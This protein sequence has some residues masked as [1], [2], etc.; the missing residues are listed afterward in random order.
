MISLVIIV[1]VL[2]ILAI[3]F[4]R[5]SSSS[6]DKAIETKYLQELSEVKKG[7]NAKRL[8]NSKKGFDEKTLNQGFTKVIVENAPEYFESFDP[9]LV[10]GYVVNLNVI[11][12]KKSGLGQGYLDFQTNDVVTFDKD[13][14]YL[15]D[16]LGTVYYAKGFLATSGDNVYMDSEDMPRK[17]GPTINV[18]STANGHVE[19]EV[20]PYYGGKITSVLVGAQKATSV[21]GKNFICDVPGNGSYIVIATEE[22]GNSTRVSITVSDM[23]ITSPEKPVITEV[24]I[25]EKEAYLGT[26]LVTLHIEATNASH[27]YVSINTLESPNPNVATGWRTYSNAIEITLEEG[28]NKVYVWCKNTSNQ[29]SEYAMT[30]V[31][32][33]TI[34][35]TT[36]PPSYNINVF[37]IEVTANQTDATT[38]SF[39]YG[40]REK[41]TTIF[42]WQESNIIEDV[43]PGK[44]MEIKTRATDMVGNSSESSSTITDELPAIPSDIKITEDVSGWSKQKTITIE[45]PVTAGVDPYTKYY[46]INGGNPKKV[47]EDDEVV[48]INVIQNCEIEAFVEANFSNAT[49]IRGEI[50]KH[51]VTKIDRVQPRLNL[52]SEESQDIYNSS[53]EIMV[54]AQD[55]ESGL[56]AWTVTTEA[57]EPDVWDNEISQTN[58]EQ[59]LVFEV[60]RDGIYY[61]WAK[62]ALGN[63]DYEI[64]D[65]QNIDLVDPEIE[66]YEVEYKEGKAVLTA[67]IKDSEKGLVAYAWTTGENVV[68]KEEDWITIERTINS[69]SVT[70]IANEND[71]YTIWAKDISGRTASAQK[72][73][74]VKFEVT[75]DFRTNGGTKLTGNK[76]STENNKILVS[77][78]TIIDLTPLAEKEG[79]DFVGW[80]RNPN[81]KNAESQIEVGTKE[82]VIVY[83]IFA[84]KV[85]LSLKYIDELVLKTQKVTGYLYNEKDTVKLEIPTIKAPYEDWILRGWTTQKDSNA[86]VEYALEGAVIE[87]GEE[88]ELYMLYEKDITITYRYFK[89]TSILDTLPIYTNASDVEKITRAEF[90]APV[91]AQ[92]V[93]KDEK[94]NGWKFRGWSEDEEPT[95]EIYVSNENDFNSDKDLTL[96]ASYDTEVTAKKKIYGTEEVEELKGKAYLSWNGNVEKAKINLGT[97]ADITYKNNTWQAKGWSLQKTANSKISVANNQEAEIHMDTEFFAIY[98]RDVTLT[99]KLYKDQTIVLN[100]NGLLNATGDMAKAS[101]K[102]PELSN[103][104]IQGL[105]WMPRGYSYSE[106]TNATIEYAVSQEVLTDEDITLYASYYKYVEITKTNFYASESVTGTVYANYIGDVKEYAVNLGTVDSIYYEHANWNP[107]YWSLE[108]GAESAKVADLNSEIKT[109]EDKTYYIKYGRNVT[110]TRH[111]YDSTQI[112]NAGVATLGVDQTIK[113]VTYKLSGLEAVEHEGVTWQPYGWASALDYEDKDTKT[114]RSSEKMSVH[115]D[116]EFFAVYGDAA[117]VEILTLDSKGEKV[118][119]KRILPSA[120][121]L[122][123]DKTIIK[124]TK[125]TLPELSNVTKDEMTWNPIGYL[126]SADGYTIS[127]TNGTDFK[128]SG[129]EVLV[130]ENTTYFAIY[131]TEVTVT[132]MFYEDELSTKAKITLNS[133]QE[134]GGIKI[135]LGTIEN[136]E[137]DN[138]K[139]LAFGWNEDKNQIDAIKYRMDEEVLIEGNKTFYATYTKVQVV[140]LQEFEE[141][142]FSKSIY[143]SASAYMNYSGEEKLQNIKVGNPEKEMVTIDGYKW[144]FIGWSTD[145]TPATLITHTSEDTIETA[146]DLVLYARYARNVEAILHTYNDEQKIVKGASEANTLGI[147]KGTNVDFGGIEEENQNGVTWIGNGWSTDS[148]PTSGA[149]FIEAS[150]S[151][152]EVSQDTH[153]YASYKS[154]LEVNFVGYSGEQQVTQTKN[155]TAYMDYLGNVVKAEIIVPELHAYK[156]GEENWIPD[157]YTKKTTADVMDEEKILSRFTTDRN[158]TYYGLYYRTI[159][160]TYDPNGGVM[161]NTTTEGKQYANSYDIQ[162]SQNPAVILTDEIPIRNGYTF[163]NKWV[164]DKDT[165]M[166]EYEA[167]SE[168]TLEKDTTVYAS[169]EASMYTIDY[170]PG[171]S[172][173]VYVQQI[174]YHDEDIT[175]SEIV[176]TRDGYIFMGWAA[177]EDSELPVY[178]PGDTYSTNASLELYAIWRKNVYAL[179]YNDGTMGFNTTGIP[180]EGKTL[181]REDTVW[182][183]ENEYYG[184]KDVPWYSI[185]E[186]TNITTVEFEEEIKPLWTA[187]WFYRFENLVE[188]KNIE[189][190]NTSLVKT[191]ANM[192]E[193]CTKLAEIDVTYF[194][195]LSVLSMKAMFKDCVSVRYLNIS[196][197]DATNLNSVDYMFYNCV[198]LKTI[199]SE[200]TFTLAEVPNGESVFRYCFEILGGRGTRYNSS[201]VNASMA[202]VDFGEGYAELTEGYFTGTESRIY[203]LL[204]T[205]N[206]L[207]FNI[208]GTPAEG[209]TIKES[210]ITLEGAKKPEDIMYYDYIQEITEVT[211]EEEINPISTAFWFND[212]IK[213]SSVNNLENINTEDVSSTEAMFANNKS[214]TKLNLENFD[215]SRVEDMSRMFEGCTNL[216]YLDLSSFDTKKVTNMSNMFKDASSIK[217]IY[218]SRTFDVTGVEESENMFAGAINV[219]GGQ[220]TIYA[221]TVIDKTYAK[222]DEGANGAGYFTFYDEKEVKLSAKLYESGSVSG[223][224]T[225]LTKEGVD[226]SA[227]DYTQGAKLLEIVAENLH[228]HKEKTI[229]VKVPVGMY[230]QKDSWTKPGESTGVKSVSFETLDTS[231]E[232]GIQQETGAYY[233]ETT[234][235]LTITI[236]ENKTSAKVALFVMYDTTI[237]NKGKESNLTKEPAIEVTINRNEASKLKVN[238]VKASAEYDGG[239]WLY[240]K[241]EGE[242]IYIQENT[243]QQPL[244]NMMYLA[245]NQREYDSFYKCIEV[246]SALY[247]Y[248]SLGARIDATYAGVSNTNKLKTCSEETEDGV[249][250]ITVENV[251]QENRCYFPIP[252][253]I[254]GNEFG[255]DVTS[256]TYSFVV[257]TTDYLG[258]TREDSV[259]HEFILSKV[260]LDYSKFTVQ[261]STIYVAQDTHHEGEKYYDILGSA[262]IGYDG[263]VDAPDVGVKFEYDIDTQIENVPTLKVMSVRLPLPQN[264]VTNAKI[265][266][267]SSTGNLSDTYD[268]EITSKGHSNGAYVH[269][270]TIAKG[271]GLTGDWYFKTIE[272]NISTVPGKVLLYKKDANY[273]YDSAGTFIGWVSDTAKTKFTVTYPEGSNISPV[274]KTITTRI[275]TTPKK[276]VY[277]ESSKAPTKVNAGEAFTIELTSGIVSYPYSYIMHIKKPTHYILVPDGVEITEAEYK[278]NADIEVQIEKIEAERTINDIKHSIY[279]ITTKDKYHYGAAKYN[280]D[281]TLNVNDRTRKISIDFKTEADMPTTTMMLRNLVLFCDE[282]YEARLSGSMESYIKTD[283]YDLNNNGNTTEKFGTINDETISITIQGS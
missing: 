185:T 135:K 67:T 272:Y 71:Y 11:E 276:A 214:L 28:Q 93:K 158:E 37:T 183:L 140:E 232:S 34:S 1:I 21:D 130:G 14:V 241:W 194:N 43:S 6:I 36:D 224:F 169:W 127:D 198:N 252:T 15:Y 82:D 197:F 187:S 264:I 201:K 106:D 118:T 248:N 124:Q 200:E 156:R 181:L 102:L 234:G 162:N 265:T 138:K 203:V 61:V 193:G 266:L 91:I 177:K 178:M 104:T 27:T 72:Y 260:E 236:N 219:V 92:T 167:G 50:K 243:K 9:D 35:P 97:A 239:L 160:L 155:G 238:N 229:E 144:N 10:T 213:L 242:T 132:R 117:N 64:I 116:L 171:E 207:G 80:N 78:N 231:L 147:C 253:Y 143:K 182:L 268:I 53:H 108:S 259:T 2:I 157:G 41:G 150:A 112:D 190:L 165:G 63:A 227:W 59:N 32:V 202:K 136:V 126:S 274:E 113:S 19:L 55:K 105:A 251:Y 75:Y 123:Q 134:I 49:S 122:L 107:L 249:T 85:E 99:V 115:E 226:I 119:S 62:D 180:K 230:I 39:E 4:M 168:I 77:C 210:W 52:I 54:T 7:V 148:S 89:S 139:W 217:T 22:G 111:L 16:A 42:K 86:E 26:K 13:D 152:V 30:K 204:Y 40:Y 244:T 258:E 212:M 96:Y 280:E 51:E 153:Y 247:G 137:K 250:T 101:M 120:R 69:T 278:D 45:Y 24:Y 60:E 199:L 186:K 88:T 282:G 70:T 58:E 175:I 269:A 205:D 44:Q 164:L 94:D 129:A 273:A 279:K 109:L 220:G 211:I 261:S 142:D 154:V 174:K 237:W 188:L 195:T 240:S 17:D 196:S 141:V 5:G 161:K 31:T 255:D 29:L 125:I 223:M 81:A 191:M 66:T 281:G 18:I 271:K 208:T 256:L 76:V 209:K 25:N 245:R 235:T 184:T 56:V 221:D 225:E 206:T 267:I 121:L 151:E 173:D 246:K 8:I 74:K 163:Q 133:N 38:L 131:E 192:F 114:Y 12:Y 48:T 146:T 46:R 149:N 57:I 84:K 189:N 218:V 262:K 87:I 98:T 68:P 159:T 110:M 103:A 222:I 263:I 73:V 23:V 170:Y 277:I 166:P 145:N 215:T 3:I 83:A 100:G 20:I 275:E 228:G 33:D 65:V 128:P 254:V 270:P 176:P 179:I 90:K 172:E 216:I 233:N 47:T 79:Y 95:A 283:D 257:K